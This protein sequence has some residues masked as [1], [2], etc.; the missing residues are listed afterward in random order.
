MTT[1]KPYM[2]VIATH[3]QTTRRFQRAAAARKSA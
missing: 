2:T 1:V 3:V